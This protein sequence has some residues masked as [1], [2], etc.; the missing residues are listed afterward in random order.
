[1][2]FR[3]FQSGPAISLRR[4]TARA[5]REFAE[6]QRTLNLTYPATVAGK[7]PPAGFTVDFQRT[8]VG[9]GEATFHAACDLVHR[10]RQFPTAWIAPV[11]DSL[12]AAEGDVVVT[13]ARFAGLWWLNACRVVDVV[14]PGPAFPGRS[15]RLEIAYGTLPG[16]IAAGEERFSIVCDADDR[17]WYEIHAFSRPAY[18]LAR[19]A[20]PLLRRLQ[21]RFGA[22]SLALVAAAGAAAPCS[23]VV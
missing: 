23:Q 22:E 12:P 20:Q 4:P 16:H 11:V 9:T 1:M 6:R 15:R 7:S 14:E 8:L 10:W 21:R 2:S 18:W 5:I 13:L 19:L 17:V 3:H